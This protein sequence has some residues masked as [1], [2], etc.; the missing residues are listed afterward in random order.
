MTASAPASPARIHRIELNRAPIEWDLD[1]GTV[2]FFGLST[3]M[4][5]TEPS[6]L[7]LLEPLAQEIGP[8]L[9]RILVAHSS[10]QGTDEDYHQ[11][12]TSLGETF[13]EGFLAWGEAV[14]VA[15]WGRFEL[16]VFDAERKLATVVVHN[17]WELEVQRNLEPAQRWG[18][19]F[20]MGKIIGIFTH[21]LGTTCWADETL[22]VQLDAQRVTFS[23]HPSAKTIPAELARLRRERMQARERQL[24]EEVEAKT[25]ELLDAQRRLER[26]SSE[27][28]R[29][30]DERTDELRQAHGRLVQSERIAVLGQLVAG[31]AHE[32]NN[33]LGAI[34]ASA[35]SVQD[36]LVGLPLDWTA[37]QR[38][39]AE[40]D[41]HAL[42]MALLERVN[43]PREFLDFRER[44]TLKAQHRQALEQAGIGDTGAV[45]DEL[46]G[47]GLN[48]ALEPW[49]PL[50]RHPRAI[51]I[52]RIVE[53][54]ATVV[55]GIAD[56][57]QAVRRASKIVFSLSRYNH[58]DSEGRPTWGSIQEGL[59]TV[60]TL[61]HHLLKYGVD[62]ECEFDS[63]PPLLGFHDELNQVWTNLIQNAVH[64]MEGRGR[65]RLGLHVDGDRQ[66]VSI[67]DSGGGIPEA[68]LGRI[69]EPF[70]TTKPAGEGTGL[71]LMISRQIVAK[72]GGTLEVHSDPGVGTTVRV[73]LPV[74]QQEVQA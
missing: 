67:Q 6:L 29:R 10:S 26:Y 48:E 74:R 14:T 66:L 41:Q 54:F 35:Q 15:G 30:V 71:G 53:R 46:V 47:L 44:R 25:A 63:L 69:F 13:A 20:L 65:L 60:L 33:P 49:L 9:F 40:P 16:P 3:V 7:R 18:C 32:L 2:S 1:R 11:M 68:A 45:A 17:P 5:W 58:H 4:F 8:Q 23:V 73:A 28:E 12:V 55:G 38:L 62:V 31:V 51:E 50:L 72:H 27:L 43:R 42:A 24:A 52:L 22:H 61:Y 70:F 19:P 34:S 59:E 64:A 21:A 56:V 39:C 57:S 37:L 36:V